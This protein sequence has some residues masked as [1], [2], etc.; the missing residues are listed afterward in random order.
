MKKLYYILTLTF[1][2][3]LAACSQEEMVNKETE[4]NQ[5]CI[6]AELP[7]DI[8][9][10]RVQIAVPADYKLRCII[11]VWTKS[12]SPTLKYR[13]EVAV[14]GGELPTFDFGLRP[15]DYSCLM[16]ADFIKKN[17]VTSEVTSEDVTY[18]HF[19]DTFYD[20]S[21]LHA[22]SIKEGATDHL[23]DT[24]LCDG[25]YATL[26]IKKNATAVQQTMKMK[27]PFAKLI[28]KENDVDKFASLT[29]MTVECQLPKTF[30]VATGEPTTEMVTAMY[31]KTFQ[32]GDDTQV[33]FTS[34][35]FVPSSGLS[36]ESFILSF[37][38]D[39][40]KSRCEIPAESI[41]LKRNQ[42]LVAAGKLMGGGTVE[43]EPEPS[44]DPQI[45]DYFFID[46]T[47]SS[48]LTDKNKD[49]CVGIVYAVGVQ[50]GDNID[51]YLNVKGK[52]IRGYVMSLKSTGIPNGIFSNIEEPSFVKTGTNRCF[53]YMQ[54][55]GGG[56][57]D[58]AVQVLSK[59]GDPD[60]TKRDGAKATRKLLTSSPY[61]DAVEPKHYSALYV[62]E[63]W[64]ENV[65]NP[66]NASEWYLPASGQLYEAVGKCYGFI[67][68]KDEDI[69]A[70]AWTINS[71][72]VLKTALNNAITA[73]IAEDF[74]T[75]GNSK[76]Y[77]IYTST[78]GRDAMPMS[79]QV[80]KEQVTMLYPKPNYKTDGLIR[81]FLTIIK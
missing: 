68:Q 32:P 30:S 31:D 48:E 9:A 10:T 57:K 18:T 81:P 1:V 73:G 54:K 26:D 69:A 12:T 40:G 78:L 8:A 75:N 74:P 58:D 71:N 79:I 3:L 27:R 72:D 5:V 56:G 44:D 36:M 21:D 65:T 51:N 39:A 46:G 66:A 19:E 14:A 20:T 25:F 80:G 17:A 33:L 67:P 28:V 43:P 15:G 7:A 64:R 29:G 52:Q 60:W 53:F 23:F 55:S 42:Q 11:E 35:V 77:Y 6:S 63:K 49:N 34:Y 50:E 16:W 61:N 76:G 62:F 2:T 41:N 45:G 70:K 37:D 59:G 24:D 13:Q 38:T 22:V 47:W 4:D